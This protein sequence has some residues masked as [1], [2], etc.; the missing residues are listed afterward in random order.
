MIAPLGRVGQ[1]SEEVLKSPP[2]HACEGGGGNGGKSR[3]LSLRR[4][5]RAVVDSEVK[6]SSGGRKGGADSIWKT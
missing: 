6:V 2:L 4:C 3:R 5:P 1:D